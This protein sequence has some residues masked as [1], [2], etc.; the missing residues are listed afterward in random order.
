MPVSFDKLK[1]GGRYTRIELATLW[2]YASYHAIARGIVTPQHSNIIIIFITEMKEGSARQYVDRLTGN[3]LETE[4]PDDHFAEDRIVAADSNRE[5][6]HL[7]YR[8]AHRKDFTYKGQ[9]KLVRIERKTHAPS[10]FT[11]RIH[12]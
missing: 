9:M 2:G 1:V 8:F 10:K 4:G 12:P 5:Q 3:I 11:Y 6:I 7:L